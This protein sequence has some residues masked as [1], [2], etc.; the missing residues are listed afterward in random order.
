[1]NVT[2]VIRLSD[3]RDEMNISLGNT[4]MIRGFDFR[5]LLAHVWP[6]ASHIVDSDLSSFFAV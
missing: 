4:S 1:M 2:K 5:K 3:P 6:I